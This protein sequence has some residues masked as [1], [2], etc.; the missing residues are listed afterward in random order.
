MKTLG[1]CTLL[2]SLVTS[3]ASAAPQVTAV[4]WT[5]GGGYRL[6]FTVRAGESRVYRWG[7]DR[8][9]PLELASP[10]GWHGS[11]FTRS[12]DW[13]ANSTDNELP[14]GQLLLGCAAT[15]PELPTQID[16]FVMQMAAPGAYYGTLV[17]TPVPE[18]SSLLALGGGVLSLLG[19][20]LRRRRMNH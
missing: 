17:P 16:Y 3:L 12:T 11:V 18:P 8:I 2:A 9:D 7:F 5:V 15:F 13:T 10:E 1:L 19:L 14:P 20:R 4:Y 6:D